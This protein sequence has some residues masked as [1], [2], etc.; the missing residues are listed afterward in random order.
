MALAYST[1]PTVI[2]LV[3]KDFHSRVAVKDYVVP[4]SV[5]DPASDLLSALV[6]IR[7]NLVTA[8][9]AVTDA[10]LINAFISI[11]QVEDTLSL[12][13]VDCHVNEKAS[14]VVALEAGEGKKATFQ[15]PS[16]EDGIFVG[17]SGPNY[18]VVDVEDATLNTLLDMFQTTGGQFTISDGET[19]ADDT[20]PGKSGRRIFA[21]TGKK[22]VAA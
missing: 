10:L 2:R 18:D 14:I 20:Y 6:T 21:K 3:Y 7:D 19:M 4:T 9:N 1:G 5:W 13:A 12:P 15:I 8:I 22:K 16:P 11:K 17:A